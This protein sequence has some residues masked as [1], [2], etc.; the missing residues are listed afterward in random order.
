MSRQHPVLLDEIADRLQEFGG[1]DRDDEDEEE[2]AQP[3]APTARARLS[4]SRRQVAAE[5]I[6]AALPRKARAVVLGSQD[7]YLGVRDE[8]RSCGKS[9]CQLTTTSS[10]VWLEDGGQD[11]SACPDRAPRQFVM[12]A[13][14]RPDRVDFGYRAARWPDISPDVTELVR[15]GI[16]SGDEVDVPVL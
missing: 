15:Q 8:M 12:G 10:L 7:I 2:E 1:D 16:I 6:V 9:P 4:Y 14:R 11:T 13:P 3:N 5:L